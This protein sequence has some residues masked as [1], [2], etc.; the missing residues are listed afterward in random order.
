MSN[1][2][3]VG[4]LVTGIDR[5]L[6]RSIYELV[7]DQNDVVGIY[8]WY[9]YNGMDRTAIADRGFKGLR[10]HAEFRLAT[11]SDISRSLNM[12]PTKKLFNLLFKLGIESTERMVWQMNR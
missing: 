10:K 9:A 7:E 1:P 6:I 4:D 12:A 11:K 3:K 5:S 8:E 2:F